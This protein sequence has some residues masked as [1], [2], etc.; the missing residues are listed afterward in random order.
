MGHEKAIRKQKNGRQSARDDANQTVGK[1]T[2]HGKV[3]MKK[4][5]ENTFVF[6]ST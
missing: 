2:S 5:H 4:V 6:F 3:K 1:K